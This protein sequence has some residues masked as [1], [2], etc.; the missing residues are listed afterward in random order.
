MPSRPRP[1]GTTVSYMHGGAL[2][3]ARP[4]ETMLI[5]DRASAGGSE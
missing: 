4:F 3:P 2:K 1:P 5:E